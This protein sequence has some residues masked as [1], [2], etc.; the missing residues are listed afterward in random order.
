ML[1]SNEKAKIE[2]HCTDNMGYNGNTDTKVTTDIIQDQ[3]DVTLAD[4]EMLKSNEKTQIEFT[5]QI[6][7][8]WMGTKKLM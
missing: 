1:K 7:L 4:E 6:M 8:D 5:A 2:S 3:P